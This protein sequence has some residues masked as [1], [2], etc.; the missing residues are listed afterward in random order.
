M[1]VIGVI[2]AILGL[3]IAYKTYAKSSNSERKKFTEGKNNLLV[4]FKIT[5]RLSL[6][7]QEL[8]QT[9]IN[10]GHINE[11]I[12]ENY[13]NEMYLDM[14]KKGFQTSLSDEILHRLNDLDLSEAN[15]ETMLR[16]I[17]IQKNNLQLIKNM[18]IMKIQNK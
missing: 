15:I 4:I 1:E 11:Y 13:T 10:M 7:V 5:Q 16:D 18:L 8:I 12:F 2:I 6:E 14:L 9:Y 17:E 3:I